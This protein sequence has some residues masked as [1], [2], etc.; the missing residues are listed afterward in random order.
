MNDLQSF[1]Q[2]KEPGVPGE[3]LEVSSG[4]V[5]LIDQYMVA[6]PS[7]RKRLSEGTSAEAVVQEFGGVVVPLEKGTYSVLRNPYEQKMI[8]CPLG[9]I[10]EGF[11]L[12]T[13][14]FTFSGAVAVETR[15]MVIFDVAL[16]SDQQ[17]VGSYRSKWEQGT[18]G[19]K[20]ARDLL[21]EKGAA[22]RYGFSRQFEEISVG[23]DETGERLGLWTGVQA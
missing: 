11:V 20:E 17:L 19:Q 14:K 15:C 8:V 21:R 12:D 9:S 1:P 18:Q 13:N 6:C 2:G 23:V 22:V 5:A 16:L 3:R 7:L 4:R 10:S